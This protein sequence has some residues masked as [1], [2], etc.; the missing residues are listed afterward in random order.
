ML[1]GL[2]SSLF[3]SSFLANAAAAGPEGNNM[4][5]TLMFFGIVLVFFY[6]I[7]WRPEQ[8]RRKKMNAERDSLKT[9]DRVTAMGILGDVV[10]I[11]DATVILKMYDGAMIEVL[12]QA[13]SQVQQPQEQKQAAPSVS[14]PKEATSK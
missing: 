14:A 9:G 2:I 11:T 3:S 4:M 7:L 5:R 13:I 8:K 1:D 12:K 6:L 10:E